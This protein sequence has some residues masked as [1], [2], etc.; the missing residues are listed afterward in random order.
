MS[1]TTRALR[2]AYPWDGLRRPRA[3]VAVVLAPLVLG[4]AV[5]LVALAYQ[6]TLPYQLNAN[7][8]WNA[9]W[10]ARAAAGQTL[11]PDPGATV[12]NNYP[13]LSF[14]LVGALSHLGVAPWIIGRGLAWLSLGGCALLIRAILRAHGSGGAT[15]GAF[16]FLGVMAAAFHDYVGMYDPQLAA[17]C[18][19]LLGLWL[20]LRRS[21]P[22]AGS[23]VAAAVVMVAAGFIKHNL[24]ALPAATTVWLALHHRTLLG[25]WLGAAA[26]SLALGFLACRTCF[27]PD[28]IAGLLTPRVWAVGLL[29]PKLAL[30]LPPVLPLALVSMLPLALPGRDSVSLLLAM[31]TVAALCVGCLGL[32]GDGVVYSA[33]FELLVAG[34]LGVG[35]LAG[36]H[37]RRPRPACLALLAAGLVA[38]STLVA[39]VAMVTYRDTW[40]AAQQARAQAAQRAVA[41]IAAQ[42][43]PALCQDQ[44]LCAWA[45]KPFAVDLFNYA[46][47]VRLG[48]R[49]DAPLRRRIVDQAFGAI[50][51]NALDGPLPAGLA[52]V[53][54]QAYRP[55]ADVPG[56]YLP[57]TRRPAS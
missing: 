14:L 8:G 26:A 2:Q 43:G 30:W 13:P 41:I 16:L 53:I 44:L 23:V 12:F 54:E 21:A 28:F 55:V 38:V 51:L 33:L 3:A 7:E 25:R 42:P 46:E 39:A 11:Y 52:A 29:W 47:S 56:L 50:Q 10:A 24:V 20:L 49:T 27:G 36:D 22:T 45:G 18:V 17:Q 31:F 1:S 34:A 15:L 57:R 40:L 4:T 37:L 35:V 19:M 48:L 5:L 32:G 6:S 9:A